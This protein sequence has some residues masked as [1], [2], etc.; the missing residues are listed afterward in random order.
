MSRSRLS[1][2]PC[3]ACGT[4]RI[5]CEV[6]ESPIDAD[7]VTI[8]DN[9][10]LGHVTFSLRLGDERVAF[11]SECPDSPMRDRMHG[12]ACRQDARET[13]RLMRDAGHQ[14]PPAHGEHH[15]IVM[16]IRCAGGP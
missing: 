8:H 7:T 1:P 16:C 11:V 14:M 10:V 2:Q 3:G 6:C 9:A 5:L 12:T 4:A 13:L 15:A